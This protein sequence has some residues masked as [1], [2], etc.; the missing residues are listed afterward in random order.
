ML[1]LVNKDNDLEEFDIKVEKKK[2]NRRSSINTNEWPQSSD[3]LVYIPYVLQNNLG[4][5]LFYILYLFSTIVIEAKFQQ[6]T[7]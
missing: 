4:K 6:K 7:F 2:R 1:R 3:G 5:K